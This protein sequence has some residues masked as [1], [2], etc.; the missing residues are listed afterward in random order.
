[1]A[2]FSSNSP[3]LSSNVLN[4]ASANVNY[5][6]A[7]VSLT[8]LFFMMGFITCLNDILIPVLKGAFALNYTESMLVQ[9]CFFTS[10]LVMSIPSGKIVQKLGYKKGMIIGF[11]GAGIGC[12]LFYPAAVNKIYPLFLTALFILASGV[13][14]LQV[15]ANPYVAI[16]GNPKTASSRL[17][18][19]Q[20]FNSVGT[21]LA[22]QFG[23]F[24]IL[25][26]IIKATAG[27]TLTPEQI[28]ENLDKIKLPYIGIAVTLFVIATI[29]GLLKLPA[30][31]A[32][33]VIEDKNNQATQ[34]IK[35][36]WDFKH[37]RFGVIGI[38]AYVGAEVAIGSF[39]IL[40]M[41]KYAGLSEDLASQ[42][43]S[44]YWG[45]A[46]IGRFIGSVILQKFKA[47]YVLAVAASM[48]FVLV[49]CAMFTSGNFAMWALLSVGLC[50][51]IMFPT[52]FTLAVRGVGKHTN[53]GSGFL[54]TA[55][56]GG[57]IIPALQGL[58]ADS[59]SM[60]FSF[61]LPVLCYIY[62]AWYGWKGSEAKA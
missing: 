50:N 28:S 13:T 32:E 9:F 5:T 60:Q 48:A 39:L 30:V 58:I 62:I 12:L 25:N 18:L 56:F 37:L 47:G 10:Y 14:L 11:I 44:Y 45:G 38:F 24:L 54:S 35:S 53:Q 22:P 3:K 31:E 29:L 16:L 7:L 34:Q 21:T 41:E 23:A 2:S 8:I 36:A 43:L 49:L 59:I 51:S 33:D 4:N 46:M 19:T 55:I 61:I 26:S 42:H 57:A 1:M 40:F 17:T 27:T 6:P 52:I 20:A 15:A